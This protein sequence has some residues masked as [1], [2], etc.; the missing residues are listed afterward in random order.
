MSVEST[1]IAVQIS[2]SSQANVGSR[3]NGLIE[4]GIRIEWSIE[5]ENLL[6]HGKSNRNL[7]ESNGNHR[8][9]SNATSTSSIIHDL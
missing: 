1:E 8:M 3:D 4:I 7:S 2:R 9:E 5:I 6:I